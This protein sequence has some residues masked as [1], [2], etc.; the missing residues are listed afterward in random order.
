MLK[1]YGAISL[2]LASLLFLAS[3]FAADTKLVK[4]VSDHFEFYTTDNEAAAKPALDHFETI[5]Q[6]LLN[7]IHSPDPF[8]GPVRIVA[9][10][11]ASEFSPYI[12][13]GY[14]L[15][16]KAFSESNAE[17]TTI[18]LASSKKEIY[19]YGAREYTLLLFEK[20]APKM[21]YWLRYGFSQLYG[22]LHMDNSG[23]IVLG[24]PPARDYRG[25]IS[26]DFDMGV[27]FGLKGGI[28]TNKGAA[29]FYAESSQT[30]VT[31]SKQGAAMA[32]MESSTTIDYPAVLWYLTHM[33]MFQK[34]YSQ[35]F[36]AF[37]SALAGGADSAQAVEQIFGQS[38]AGLKQDVILYIKLSSHATVARPFQLEKP[39]APQMS[40]L[41]AAESALVLADLKAAK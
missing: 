21:P 40:Q 31:N 4:A 11:S 39:V 3:S 18:V 14:D 36:G 30:A 1:R 29:D 37:V 41:N 27:M 25:S 22:S 8:A 23:Q 33:L 12:P 26:Q 16:A 10:K 38:L 5:R 24:A 28:S 2:A 20:A 6:Y 34:P 9:F 17:R 32:N 13:K 15:T 35:K 7:S 19:E